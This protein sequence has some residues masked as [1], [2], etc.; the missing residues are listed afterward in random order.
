MRMQAEPDPA[1]HILWPI[2]TARDH[3]VAIFHRPGEIALLM[4]ATHALMLTHRH[5][6]VEN[7][8]FRAAADAG[9]E[10]AQGYNSAVLSRFCTRN[11]SLWP[12]S[13]H[14]RAIID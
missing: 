2:N 10:S 8:A 3:A 6:A 12:R 14:D 4:R 7:Q 1:K 11:A 13:S 9:R 5:L